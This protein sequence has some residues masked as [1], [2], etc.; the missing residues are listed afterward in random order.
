MLNNFCYN[1]LFYRQARIIVGIQSS[2]INRQDSRI[3]ASRD[4]HF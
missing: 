3:P 2:L 4:T 1:Y